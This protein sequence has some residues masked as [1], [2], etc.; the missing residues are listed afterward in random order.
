MFRF[1]YALF[2]LSMAF[3]LFAQHNT[4]WSVCGTQQGRSTWLKEYQLKPHQYQKGGDTT[5]YV[6]MA[7]HIV[8]T[9]EGSGYY[10]EASLLDA[11]CLLNELFL[12][13]GIQ[14][15]MAGDVLY[16]NNSAYYAHA[17][18][19]EGY[20][21]MAQYN[22]AGALN[23][24][25]VS[26][27]AGNCGYNLPYAGIANSN[28]CSGASDVTWAHEVGHALSLPHP[29][30][31][32][33]GGVSWDGS[34]DHN[35]ADPAPERVTYDYTFFQD[36]LIL[37]TLIID[38]AYVERLD[39]SNCHFAADGFCDTPPDYLASRWSCNSNGTSPS[40]Q[41]DPTG[42]AFQSEGSFIMNYANDACQIR[43]SDEQTQAMRAFLYDQRSHWILT[44]T[45]PIPGPVSEVPVLLAP[46]GGETQSA[47]AGELS[48]NAVAEATQYVVQV[49]R[50][51][52][53]PPALTSTYL[54][55]TNNIIT[56]ELD[57]GRTYYW[58][59]KGFNAYNSCSEFSAVESFMIEHP[60][61]TNEVEQIASWRLIPQPL[62][63]GQNI[64]MQLSS[65]DSWTA[66]AQI[67]NKSGQLVWQERLYL[68]SGMQLI[69]LRSTNQLRPG[70]YVLR[71]LAEEKQSTLR[72]IVQ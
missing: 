16:H 66:D 59:V 51:S 13:T 21:M 60:N 3:P 12:P 45:L 23:T 18:V 40:T 25:F 20:E 38:T 58:R 65:T 37:D 48:W 22:I 6:A 43:F 32:W 24:Y 64:Q 39:G 31:G 26:D 35:F 9:D 62:S 70:A 4:E 71:L 10:S 36:T 52:S 8:G 1:L 15:V 63:S 2:L 34:V 72:L 33:E 27:P 19:L 54:S 30:L 14:F 11:F 44:P 53:F 29:F 41:H 42:S 47:F 50:L 46:L 17:T 56:D 69:E 7:I 68:S 57:D 28:S 55:S 5:V 61:N 49:S 67:I